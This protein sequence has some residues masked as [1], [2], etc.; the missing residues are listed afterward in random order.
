MQNNDRNLVDIGERI[1][2]NKAK[3]DRLPLFKNE[4]RTARLSPPE[5]DLY[6]LNQIQCIALGSL[7]HFGW[8]L[9]FIRRSPWTQPVIVV[10]HKVHSK[11]AV[12]E[13]DGSVN[14]SPEVRWRH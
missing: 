1:E 14:L 6:D 12:L 5:A 8:Q 3:L 4:L 11:L 2:K 10:K 9:A 7:Q 13:E